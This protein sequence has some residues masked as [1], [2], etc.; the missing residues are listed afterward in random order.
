MQT[1]RPAVRAIIVAALSLFFCLV[2]LPDLVRVAG[3]PNGDLGFETDGTIVE[4]VASGG[5]AQRAGI[6]PGMRIDLS[7]LT[8]IRRSAVIGGYVPAPGDSVTF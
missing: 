8:A 5:P 2:T 7:G 6:R 1:S 4:S 3:H